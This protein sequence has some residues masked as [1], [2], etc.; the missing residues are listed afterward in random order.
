MTEISLK[1]LCFHSKNRLGYPNEEL[2]KNY[3]KIKIRFSVK[4]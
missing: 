2:E 1:P 4:H 3:Q